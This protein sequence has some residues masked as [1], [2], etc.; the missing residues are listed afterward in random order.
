MAAKFLLKELSRY[1]IGTF[2]DIVYRNALL[3][4]NDEAFVYGDERITFAQFNARVNSLIVNLT[5]LGVKKGELLGITAWN[6]AEYMYVEA[7]AMKGGFIASPYNPKLSRNEIL[8]L[9][10]Y[11]EATVVFVGP[12]NIDVI[13]SLRAEDRIPTVKHFIA[14]EK[15]AKDFIFMGDLI[16]DEDAEEPNVTVGED[17]PFIVFYTSGTT[18]LPKGAVFTNKRRIENHRMKALEMGVKLGSRHL[19]IIPLFHTGG[20]SHTWIMFYMGGCNVM[21]KERSFNPTALLE[22]IQKEKITDVHLVPT[23]IVMLI[24]QPD[25]SKYDL[26]TLKHIFYAGSAMPTEVLR[27]AVQIFGPVFQQGYG[28]TETGPMSCGMYERDHDVL[29]KSPEEQEVL[30]SCGRPCIGAHVR[31]VDDKGYDLPPRVPGEIIIMHKS[32]MKEYWHKPVETASTIIDGW[33]H[34]GDVGFYDEKGFIYIVDR[35]SD[36]IITGGENVYPREIEEILYRIPDVVEAA[37]IG[38]PDPVWVEKVHAVVVKKKG[39]ELSEKDVADFCKDKLAGFKRPKSI[40]FI[41]ELPKNPQG[42]ILKREL[43]KA[44]AEK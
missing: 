43:R 11:S 42:K 13:S 31:I 24:N 9:I 29:D 14:M 22:T 3:Y 36:M 39:S 21:L 44:F 40:Q 37:V 4:P 1:P 18:G 23:Q 41:D 16:K 5:K 6:C 20:D 33:V 27:K 2:A 35:K 19:T 26:S 10:N 25:V 12:E 28:L 7:A 34:S 15:P 8:N 30:K 38:I 32:I 17:D